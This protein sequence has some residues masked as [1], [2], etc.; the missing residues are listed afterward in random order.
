MH[1]PG[2][3][4]IRSVLTLELY[5][6]VWDEC[7]NVFERVVWVFFHPVAACVFLLVGFA[8]AFISGVTDG[9]ERFE[10]FERG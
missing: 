4:I 5:V 10:R 8:L 6:R 7:D 9:L 1:N 2:L 3:E